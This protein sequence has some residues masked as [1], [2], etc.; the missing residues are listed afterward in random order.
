MSSNALQERILVTPKVAFHVHGRAIFRR[1]KTRRGASLL[2]AASFSRLMLVGQLFSATRNL[3]HH[4]PAGDGASSPACHVSFMFFSSPS[5]PRLCVGI[6]VLRGGTPPPPPTKAFRQVIHTVT[7]LEILKNLFQ[8][9]SQDAEGTPVFPKTSACFSFCRRKRLQV[10]CFPCRTRMRRAWRWPDVLPSSTAGWSRGS[11]SQQPAGEQRRR[12]EQAHKLSCVVGVNAGKCP[13]S[14]GAPYFICRAH[15]SFPGPRPGAVSPKCLPFRKP[16]FFRQIL[17]EY[18]P[19][20]LCGAC[21]E[22][23]SLVPWGRR[24]TS[25]ARSAGP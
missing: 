3:F 8:K 25:A 18:P 5:G 1:R 20:G 6:K 9:V 19:Q 4:K 2:F 12:F 21:K 22:Q 10:V 23:A 17:G 16:H 13:G 15:F 14:P 24:E 7:F 11:M